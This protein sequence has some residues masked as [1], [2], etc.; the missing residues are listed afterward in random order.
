MFGRLRRWAL[1]PWGFQQLDMLRKLRSRALW[2][3][4]L[5]HISMHRIL[6]SGDLLFFGNFLVSDELVLRL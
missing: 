5:H 4:G 2:H 1:R 6:C 3:G